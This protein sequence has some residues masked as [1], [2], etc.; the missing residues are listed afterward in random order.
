MSVLAQNKHSSSLFFLILTI[1]S[2]IKILTA[3]FVGSPSDSFHGV[4]VIRSETKVVQYIVPC[5]CGQLMTVL[6][7]GEREQLC[8]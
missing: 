3:L 2:R 5:L 7:C 8:I 1:L 6:T 4:H